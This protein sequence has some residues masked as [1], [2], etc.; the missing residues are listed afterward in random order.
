MISPLTRHLNLTIELL[1]SPVVSPRCATPNLTASLQESGVDWMGNRSPQPSYNTQLSHHGEFALP[2]E[3]IYLFMCRVYVVADVD[4]R[5][6]AHN[7]H[8]IS[9]W[10]SI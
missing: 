3:F 9:T 5:E 6:E 10:V 4:R 8:R 2:A 7:L 1:C